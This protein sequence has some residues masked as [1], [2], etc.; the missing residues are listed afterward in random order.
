MHRN[1]AW[2][3]HINMPIRLRSRRFVKLLI[4]ARW[5]GKRQ[6]KGGL[7]TGRHMSHRTVLVAAFTY[8]IIEISQRQRL[9]ISD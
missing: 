3:Q 7:E 4:Q 1:S 5:A 2:H 9:R 8:L 6:K